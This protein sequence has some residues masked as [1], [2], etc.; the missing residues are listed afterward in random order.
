[1]ESDLA[2]TWSNYARMKEALLTSEIARGAAEE[3]KRRARE[4][5][6]VEKTRSRG[7]FDDIDHIKKALREKEDAIL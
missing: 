6:E 3:A 5:L 4:D 1:M 7:L 2:T